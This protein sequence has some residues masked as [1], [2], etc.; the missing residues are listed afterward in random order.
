[1]NCGALLI[2]GDKRHGGAASAGAPLA[3]QRAER[4]AAAIV[5][6]AG[7]QP[8][9]KP[10]VSSS[11]FDLSRSEHAVYFVV[12]LSHL[13]GQLPISVSGPFQR[14]GQFIDAQSPSYSTSPATRGRLRSPAGRPG[15]LRLGRIDANSVGVF[16]P[17][18]KG[19]RSA[20]PDAPNTA[21]RL[22][23]RLYGNLIPAEMT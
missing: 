12:V 13:Y 23:Y 22:A 4:R 3:G 1:M 21:R 5:G 11:R 2:I 10:A 7:S 6:P 15:R 9:E 19:C 17:A 14:R 8:S 18:D 16:R 20:R